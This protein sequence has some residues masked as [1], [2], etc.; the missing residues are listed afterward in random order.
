MSAA[1]PGQ[2]LPLISIV[3]PAYNAELHL[4][5]AIRS[6]LASDLENLELLV[7]DD[8][9]SDRSL[10]I[11]RGI[12]DPRMLVI[13]QKA[14]GGPSRPRNVG[15]ARSRAPYIALLDAD[16]LLKPDKLSLAV[17]ALEAHPE[18]GVAFADYERIDDGGR[19]LEAAT[20]A[21][22]PVFRTLRALPAA[23]PWRLI[24]QPE[25]ARGLLH[26]NF[27]GTSGVVLRRSALE[28]VGVFDESLTYSEDRDLWFRLA[29]HGAALYSDRIGHAYRV[30]PGSL[31]FRPGV[32]Q[33]LNRITVLRRERAR[34]NERAARRQIDRL[35][36]E[37]LAAIAYDHRKGGRRLRSAATFLRATL[38]SPESRWM[39]AALGSLAGSSR[40]AS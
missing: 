32:R 24:P 17:R 10:E 31:S 22:Y 26:E 30:S 20:L 15:I 16:D 7:I 3:M 38:T 12:A 29:H 28:R 36:A 21:G 13:T 1:L 39:R 4:E 18:A 34:W 27:I 14:S 35:I 19:V 9:S 40:R 33:A 6:A 25:F 2:P 23:E 37:N 5:S 11:A 8:G